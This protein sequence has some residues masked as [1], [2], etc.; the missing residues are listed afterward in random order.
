MAAARADRAG[1]T[2]VVLD[3]DDH[4]DSLARA[5]PVAGGHADLANR[6]HDAC[7]DRRRG[8]RLHHAARIDGTGHVAHG[9]VGDSDRDR[10]DRVG[11][12]RHGPVNQA[13]GQCQA[14]QECRRND[15]DGGVTIRG[16]ISHGFPTV[17]CRFAVAVMT[18]TRAA[19]C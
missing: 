16:D 5:D 7:R 4:H 10:L 3:G 6:R 11:R 13:F 19:I 14:R 8:A 12:S 18:L 2:V 9:D 1:Q 17:R 15:G